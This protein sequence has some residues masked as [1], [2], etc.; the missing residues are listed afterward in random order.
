MSPE[1]KSYF[2]ERPRK[3]GTNEPPWST[4]PHDTHCAVLFTEGAHWKFGL[5]RLQIRSRYE[6]N[7]RISRRI[8][9]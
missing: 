2:G 4:I 3:S 6:T 7:F 1:H 9:N 8:N 5:M